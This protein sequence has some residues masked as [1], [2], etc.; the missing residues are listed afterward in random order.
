LLLS[1]P[2]VGGT[3]VPRRRPVVEDPKNV[4]KAT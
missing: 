1:W 2:Y 3:T 4:Q